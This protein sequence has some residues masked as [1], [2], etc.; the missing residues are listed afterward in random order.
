MN[1][2]LSIQVESLSVFREG[3]PA[4]GRRRVIHDLSLAF[5]SGERV[6]IVGANGAGKSSLLLAL[7]GALPFEGDVRIGNLQLK[8]STLEEVRQHVGFVFAEPADQLFL[9][10]VRDEVEL[11]PRLRRKSGE[12]IRTRADAALAAV[13]LT[14]FEERAPTS[15]SLGEQ[16]RLALATVLSIDAGAL[17]LDEPTASLDG[18]ARREVLHAMRS[19]SGTTL[20]ATHDLDAALELDARAVLL[21]E[22]KLVATGPAREL[23]V[24]RDVLDRAGLELPLSIR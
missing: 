19:L 2:G 8:K 18:R 10:T 7:V 14:G 12:E 15:L 21:S 23:L 16:R 9:A 1:M 22:G 20:F 3:D 5:K 13:K 24:D 4:A 6:A 11:G 17:L